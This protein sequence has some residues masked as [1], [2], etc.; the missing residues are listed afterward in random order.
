MENDPLYI[1]FNKYLLSPQSKFDNEE[2][3]IYHVVAEY[4]YLLMQQ[5]HIVES[6]LDD[7]ETDLR[8]EVKELLCKR[9]YGFFNL[10]QYRKSIMEK[11]TPTC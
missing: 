2:E 1:I 3:F 6:T 8:E 7:I 9:I 4:I 10:K 11:S 5:G